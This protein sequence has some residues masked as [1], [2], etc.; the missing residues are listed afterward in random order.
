MTDAHQN[1]A[2]RPVYFTCIALFILF[3]GICLGM[4]F[5]RWY[6]RSLW[7][8]RSGEEVRAGGTGYSYINPLLECSVADDYI[9]SNEAKPSKERLNR[10]IATLKGE[11][12]ISHVSIYFRN[13]NDGPWIGINEKEQFA[14]ASLLKVPMML[15]MLK[16]SEVD[17]QYFSKKEVVNFSS[18]LIIKSN[19]EDGFNL[20]K[21]KEYSLKELMEMM[22]IHSN[23]DA[24]Y[25]LLANNISKERLDSVF[26]DLHIELLNDGVE[27][28]IS[29][30]DY[31]AFFRVLFNA[32]Y[33]SRE[34]SEYALKILSE[35]SFKKGLVAGVPPG[36]GVAHKYGERGGGELKQLHDCGIVYLPG[37]PYLLCVMTRGKDFDE[38]TSAIK[39]ISKQV[40]EDVALFSPASSKE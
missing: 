36:I 31:A 6:W 10:L 13:L 19:F 34:S 38:L 33:L 30:R 4:T 39:K 32:S 18:N 15:S 9:G 3:V 7:R 16:S 40:Y 14:P 24:A 11:G 37:Q 12:D 23:N 21:D 1:L 26:S 5:N 28:Y 17:P 2:K 22:V 27:N 29:V 8:V 20:E 35:S 25:T